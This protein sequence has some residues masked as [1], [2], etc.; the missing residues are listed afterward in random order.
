M[1]NFDQRGGAFAAALALGLLLVVWSASRLFS[2]Y[3]NRALQPARPMPTVAYA[4]MLI[5][6]VVLIIG[7]LVFDIADSGR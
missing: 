4:L 2:I 5:A 6:A 7:T 1:T 3:R